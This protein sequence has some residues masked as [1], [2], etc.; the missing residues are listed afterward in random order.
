MQQCLFV[1]RCVA[2]PGLNAPV[3]CTVIINGGRQIYVGYNGK[4][5]ASPDGTFTSLRLQRV[6]RHHRRHHD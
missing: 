6:T 2:A 5:P 3:A 1:Q 4:T